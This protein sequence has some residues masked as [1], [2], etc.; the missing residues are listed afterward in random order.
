VQDWLRVSAVRSKL[1][2]LRLRAWRARRRLHRRMIVARLPKHGVGAE[3]GVWRGNFSARLLRSAKPTCLHLIDPW[4]HRSE[5]A[6]ENAMFGR[7]DQSQL[8]RVYRGVHERFAHEIAH[9]QVVIHRAPSTVAL[10]TLPSL[11]WVYIDG[12]HTYEGVSADLRSC[13]ERLAQDGR[14][15]GDDYGVTGWWD[16]GVTKAVDEFAESVDCKKTVM[17]TQFLLRKVSPG[18]DGGR[19]RKRRR[20]A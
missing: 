10:A 3:I 5:P 13:W 16:D 2:R 6:Y 8:E 11:D 4:Q 18:A 20:R 12:D 17:G 14:V 7:R 19:R 9:G 1:Q 15:G